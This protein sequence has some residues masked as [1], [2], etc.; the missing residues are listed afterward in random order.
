MIKVKLLNRDGS[1]FREVE[2]A[3]FYIR[4]KAI[5]CGGIAFVTEDPEDKRDG[6]KYV[7][8]RTAV[9]SK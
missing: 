7:E 9:I 5:V 1:L 8:V 6:L 2:I 3:N 4:P